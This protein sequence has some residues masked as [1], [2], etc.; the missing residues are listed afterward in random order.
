MFNPLTAD[1]DLEHYPLQKLQVLRLAMV[2][3]RQL[4]EIEVEKVDEAGVLS[5]P[6]ILD[7]WQT[8]R[9]ERAVNLEDLALKI[10]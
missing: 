5:L 3:V 9:E 7:L 10:L 1:G 8:V 6:V 4:L 2:S